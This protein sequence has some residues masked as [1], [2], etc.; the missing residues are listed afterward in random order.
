MQNA[1]CTF[2]RI[3]LMD[4]LIQQLVMLYAMDH[5]HPLGEHDRNGQQ[6]W[7]DQTGKQQSG[8]LVMRMSCSQLSNRANSIRSRQH[9]FRNMIQQRRMCLP[10]GL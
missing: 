6:H 10:K 2:R 9:Q 5:T 1:R 8:G 3:A 4:S 7:I